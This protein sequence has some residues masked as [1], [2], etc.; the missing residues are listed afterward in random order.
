MIRIDQLS[1]GQKARCVFAALALKRPHVLILD[2]PTNHLDMESVEALIES[3]R[4]FEG[5]VVLVSHDARLISALDC[6]LWVC[7]DS[8]S[9]L[10]VERRGFDRYRIE[11]LK[12]V[13]RR[14]EVAHVEAEKRMR[15]K[16]EARDR[17]LAQRRSKRSAAGTSK[18]SRGS[19]FRVDVS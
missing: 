4:R 19:V 8:S 15:R 10:R 1:G 7:G 12:E 2:E 5:G 6:E 11:V 9:G 17:I 3:L 13:R 14:E 16:R 18:S